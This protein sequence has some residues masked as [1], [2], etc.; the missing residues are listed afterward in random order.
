MVG[1][2]GLGL[3]EAGALRLGLPWGPREEALF[4]RYSQA[5][6]EW[7]RRV[8]L[9]AVTGWEEVQRVHFLDSLTVALALSQEV[10]RGG[11]VID[12][13]TGAG[14]PGIPLKIAFPG[15]ALALVE[16]VGKKVAF[17]RFLVAHL[18]LERVQVWQGRAEDLGRCPEL[19][20]AFDGVTARALG[21]MPVLAELALPFARVGGLMV[22][23]KK[24]DFREEL[25]AALEGLALLGGRLEEV[26]WLQVPELGEPRALVVV[27]KVSPTPERFPR[28]PGVP[29]KRPLSR[30]PCR[31]PSP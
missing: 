31:A 12:L 4:L 25:E 11:R 6:E 9:T 1:E 10:R 22:A 16:S 2:R 17:L 18:R 3:L 14:F 23:Q 26:R 21:P 29:A 19:R 7:N 27:K 24:G 5:L 20:E 8:N 13:G 30:R 28:R 15:L